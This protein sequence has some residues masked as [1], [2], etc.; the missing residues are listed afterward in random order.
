MLPKVGYI[1]SFGLTAAY[2][3]DAVYRT[4]V[5]GPRLV[6]EGYI[7]IVFNGGEVARLFVNNV[8]MPL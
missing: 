1:P 8:Y 7:D 3:L 2:K 4:V 5:R 6:E